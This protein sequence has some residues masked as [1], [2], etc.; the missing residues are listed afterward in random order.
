MPV[1]EATP[2]PHYIILLLPTTSHHLASAQALP[3]LLGGFY[4]QSGAH[5]SGPKGQGL[6]RPAVGGFGMSLSALEEST[7]SLSPGIPSSLPPSHF[8]LR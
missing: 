6:T 8:L 2:P 4:L 3:S 5:S 7:S 1:R